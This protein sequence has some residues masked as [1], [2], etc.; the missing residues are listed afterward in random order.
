MIGKTMTSMKRRAVSDKR[1][2]AKAGRAPIS[3]DWATSPKRCATRLDPEIVRRRLT[4]LARSGKRRASA[5]DSSHQPDGLGRENS[6][7]G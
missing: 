4:L 3:P 6:S 2:G 1:S 7:R 5:T